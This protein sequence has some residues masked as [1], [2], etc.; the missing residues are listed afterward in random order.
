MNIY[1]NTG[2]DLGAN[3]AALVDRLRNAAI[4]IDPQGL[5]TAD[6]DKLMAWKAYQETRNPD[7]ATVLLCN[8]VSAVIDCADEAKY[9]NTETSL[10]AKPDEPDWM[11]LGWPD[12]PQGLRTYEARDLETARGDNP[13]VASLVD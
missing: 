8:L 13:M 5:T 2:I 4:T 3:A 10:P 1:D 6:I 9:D 7:A 12:A 11:A